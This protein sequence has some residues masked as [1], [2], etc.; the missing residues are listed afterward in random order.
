MV[1][2]CHQPVIE[3]QDV[4]WLSFVQWDI[5]GG[6]LGDY[7]P[8]L[9]LKVILNLMPGLTK[10]SQHQEGASLRGKKNQR[11]HNGRAWKEPESLRNVSE[12]T[13]QPSLNMIYMQD[14]KISFL[15]QLV[16]LGATV[17]CSQG[18]TT[19]KSLSA[20][21]GNSKHMPVLMFMKIKDKMKL[22][23]FILLQ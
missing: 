12:L 2:L 4:T 1:I 7:L 14:N 3:L 13:V 11:P 8:L 22:H 16:E 5:K 17:I 9:S 19:D 20:F 10:L 15:F 23:N 21:F 6:F 18:I